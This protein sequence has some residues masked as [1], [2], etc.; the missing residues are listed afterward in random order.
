MYSYGSTSLYFLATVFFIFIGCTV[1]LRCYQTNEKTKETEIVENEQF[2]YC[3][4]F[5]SLVGFT[6]FETS[7]ADGLTIDELDLPFGKLFEEN[8]N[9]YKMLSVCFY[10]KY[11]WPKAMS[12][13]FHKSQKSPKVEYILRCVCNYDLCNSPSF[14]SS[15]QLDM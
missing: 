1:S 12:P 7:S 3:V 6:H 11:N 9:V 4:I 13:K 10:E 15:H 14:F 2:E 8:D 5:P